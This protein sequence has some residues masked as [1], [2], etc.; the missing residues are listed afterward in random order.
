MSEWWRLNRS[1]ESTCRSEKESV[2][3]SRICELRGLLIALSLHHFH[4]IILNKRTISYSSFTGISIPRAF[5]GYPQLLGLCRFAGMLH[6]LFGLGAVQD[7][8]RCAWLSAV[9]GV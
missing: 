4:S 6:G 9:T 1:G 5:H 8:V 7:I 3:T 2:A